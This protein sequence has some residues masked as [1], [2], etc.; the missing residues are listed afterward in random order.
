MRMSWRRSP[1]MTAAVLAFLTVD[2]VLVAAIGLSMRATINATIGHHKS[3]AVLAAVI[4]ALAYATSMVV[5]DVVGN[6]VATVADRVGRLD[7]NPRIHLDIA[8]LER[9]DHLERPDYLNRVTVT[10]RGAGRLTR[11][12]WSAVMAVTSI[13]KLAVTVVILGEISP[14]L[15]FLVI[16]AAAPIWCDQRAQRIVGHA[17]VATAEGYR[18]QQHLFEQATS[19]ASAKE[20][21]VAGAIGEITELQSR[22]WDDVT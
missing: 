22:A 8:A 10:R 5:V 15:L 7:L 2:V 13:A 1:K 3:S 16:M 4:A 6:L 19:A 17:D 11:G 14:W 18:V 21:R 9:L 20:I 12:M